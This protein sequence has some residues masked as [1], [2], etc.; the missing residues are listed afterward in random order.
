MSNDP[1]LGVQWVKDR[2][3][4]DRFYVMRRYFHVADNSKTHVAVET[5]KPC[6]NTMCKD[7]AHDKLHK[8]RAFILLLQKTLTRAW[9]LRQDNAIDEV[10]VGFKGR[11]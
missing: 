5:G 4:R 8:L 7:P 6:P 11:D 10:I 9:T 2:W 1:Q 3:S